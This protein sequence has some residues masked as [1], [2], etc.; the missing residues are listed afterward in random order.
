MRFRTTVAAAVAAAGFAVLALAGSASTSSLPR[1]LHRH[2]PRHRART[3][4]RRW[5]S[6]RTA[7]C[8]SP[9]RAATCASSRTRAAARRRSS[10]DRRLD[11]RA[12]PARR[13]VR[14][15]LRDEP[16]RLRLLHRPELAAPTTASAASPRTATSPWPAARSSSSTSTTSSSAT[17]HNGGAIHFGPDGKLYVAVG[18][19]ANGDELADRSTTSSARSCGS[20]PTARSRPTTRS[21]ATA[22]GVNRAIWALGPAQPVHVRVPARHGPDVHQRRGREHLGGD[23]RRHRRA[24]TTAGPTPKGRDPPTRASRSPLFAYAHGSTRRRPAARSPAARSTTPRRVLPGDLR[25]QATSSPTF[26]AAGSAASIRRPGDGDRSS[27]RGI[28]TPVDLQV[29]PGR[30]PVLPRARH[31]KHPADQLP[32]P[33]DDQRLHPGE[34]CRRDP[35]GRH[36]HVPG[37]H[38]RGDAERQA[39]AVHGLLRQRGRRYGRR[40]GRRRAGSSFPP[41]QAASWGR[42][43]FTVTYSLTGFTPSSGPVGTVV[44]IKGVGFT[45]PSTVKFHGVSPVNATFVSSSQLKA[46]VPAGA[47]TGTITV[48]RSTGTPSTTDSATAF[49]VTP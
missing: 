47:T 39:R 26:A 46:T 28:S 2:A 4:P 3:R 24:R 7:A 29:G 11:G 44:T 45:N 49:T 36:W 38:D 1:R 43:P 13:R 20:T 35:R 18:E 21:T 14:P 12:R 37:R 25:R 19:N 27:R 10:P 32:A 31:R 48:I 30:E 22:T 8:S 42:T 34:R 17:N 6:R 41:R 23:R 9:S 5:R 33:A 15:E 16:L 40:R